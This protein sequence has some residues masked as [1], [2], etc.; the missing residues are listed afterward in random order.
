MLIREAGPRPTTVL[1]PRIRAMLIPARGIKAG[2]IKAG[3]INGA[4]QSGWSDPSTDPGND[5]GLDSGGGSDT[6]SLT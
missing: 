5:P 2:R 4:D 1:Q 6:D 3:R